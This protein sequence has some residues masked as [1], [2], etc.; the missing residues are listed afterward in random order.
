M[1]IFVIIAAVGLIGAILAGN[2][3]APPFGSAIG[4][5][6]GVSFSVYEHFKSGNKSAK[7]DIICIRN[8]VPGGYT[9]QNSKVV[10][11]VSLAVMGAVSAFAWQ[12]LFLLLR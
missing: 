1:T 11:I 5:L 3:F 10:V 12:I 4:I 6:A 2:S 9:K 8:G 7:T